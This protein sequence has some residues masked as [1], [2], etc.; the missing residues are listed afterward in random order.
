M[1]TDHSQVGQALRLAYVEG[2]H[3]H[4]PNDIVD[5]AFARRCN[6][7]WWVVYILDRE[8]TV[9]IGVPDHYAEDEIT[10]PM[11]VPGAHESDLLKQGCHLRIRL[12]K[13]T[14]K[15]CTGELKRFL[16]SMHWTDVKT[17]VY[18]V[19]KG[20][21]QAFIDNTTNVLQELAAVS[22]ELESVV[23]DYKQ[24]PKGELPSMFRQITLSYHHVRTSRHHG[25]S[26][27]QD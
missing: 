19:G 6:K 14:A 11:G 16:T 15:T 1:L 17:A 7:A 23:S 3:L 5:A 10:A 22:R 20:L 8:F 25:S 12:S 9:M 21:G 24:A 2:I 26:E 27:C 4:I 18:G 13:L